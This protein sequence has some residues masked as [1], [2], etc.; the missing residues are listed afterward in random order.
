[1]LSTIYKPTN[2]TNLLFYKQCP[3]SGIRSSIRK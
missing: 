2:I 1:M 3:W